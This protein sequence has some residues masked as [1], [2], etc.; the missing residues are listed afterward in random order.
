M[1]SNIRLLAQGQLEAYNQADLNK[2]CSYYHENVQVLDHDGNINFEG[3]ENFKNH[4]SKL[5]MTK[6]FGASVTNRIVLNQT[7][8][9]E[10]SWWRIDLETQNKICGNVLVRYQEK[11]KKIYLVQFFK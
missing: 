1:K 8:I 3:I 10:E 9:D 4:Y 5:F 6:K 7:C 11:D 2:F